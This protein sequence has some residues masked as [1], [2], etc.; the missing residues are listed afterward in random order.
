MVFLSV[1]CKNDHFCPTIFVVLCSENFQWPSIITCP[2]SPEEGTAAKGPSGAAIEIMCDL[3][4]E[5][6]WKLRGKSG[7]RCTRESL[8]IWIS[9]RIGRRGLFRSTPPECRMTSF[10]LSPSS[11]I[12]TIRCVTNQLGCP[13]CWTKS[14]TLRQIGPG[15]TGRRVRPAENNPSGATVLAMTCPVQ[16]VEWSLT[17]HNSETW[18]IIL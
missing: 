4:I 11:R 10:P 15:G 6:A 9:K 7:A 1:S 18:G 2:E 8:L 17:K 14:V 12:S 5:G 13:L 3:C 16:I